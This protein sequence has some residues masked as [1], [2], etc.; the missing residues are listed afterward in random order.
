M[1]LGY[2]GAIHNSS[3]PRPTSLSHGYAGSLPCDLSGERPAKPSDVDVSRGVWRRETCACG[4]VIESID[5][6]GFI[7]AA[8]ERHVR[9]REHELWRELED[10]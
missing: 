8:L 5:H 9:T 2:A 4:G 6:H 10:L 1:T 3:T 7:Q